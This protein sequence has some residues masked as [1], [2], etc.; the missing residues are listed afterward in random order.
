MDKAKSFGII[1]AT[2]QYEPDEVRASR[3]VLR[4]R[5]GAIPPRYSTHQSHPLTFNRRLRNIIS[6]RP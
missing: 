2:G 4:E 1:P 5:G 6:A 3:P